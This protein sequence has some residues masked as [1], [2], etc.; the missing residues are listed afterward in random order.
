MYMRIDITRQKPFALQVDH[1][2]TGGHA[3]HTLLNTDDLSVCDRHRDIPQR[4]A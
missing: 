4:F 2:G 3:F 1:F